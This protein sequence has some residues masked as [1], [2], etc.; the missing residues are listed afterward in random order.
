[1]AVRLMPTRLEVYIIEKI[2][3]FIYSI[4]YIIFITENGFNWNHL[5][6]HQVHFSLGRSLSKVHRHSHKPAT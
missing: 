6:I 3:S 2:N 5:V 4:N 1:M